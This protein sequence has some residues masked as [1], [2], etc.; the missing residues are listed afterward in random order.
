MIARIWHGWTFPENAISYEQLL[1]EEIFNTIRKKK[2][3][4]FNGIELLKRS[5]DNETEFTTIMYFETIDAIK[6]FAGEDYEKAVVPEKAQKLLLRYDNT[7][8]HYE[9]IKK[10]ED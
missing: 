5:V 8:Q 3:D 4:G 6:K 9:I 10:R 2:I 1:K 7:P